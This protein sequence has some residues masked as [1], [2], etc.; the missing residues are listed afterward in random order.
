[1]GIG[2]TDYE[3]N[4]MGAVLVQFNPSIFRCGIAL[5]RQHMITSSVFKL[6]ASSPTQHLAG[7]RASKIVSIWCIILYLNTSKF[8]S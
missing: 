1:M 5:S 3:I 6:G 7:Y 2:W 8:A 4:I